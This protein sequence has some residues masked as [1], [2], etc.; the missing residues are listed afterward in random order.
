MVRYIGDTYVIG[1]GVGWIYR[2]RSGLSCRRATTAEKGKTQGERAIK[3]KR[4]VRVVSGG[5]GGR[6]C[7]RLLHTTSHCRLLRAVRIRTAAR[8]S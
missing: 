1:E 4:R 7:A 2:E 8:N 5:G 3:S 6:V